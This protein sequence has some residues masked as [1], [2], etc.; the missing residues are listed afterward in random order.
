MSRAQGR[1]AAGLGARSGGGGART[2]ASASQLAGR[3]RE[4]AAGDRHTQRPISTRRG[5]AARLPLRRVPGLGRDGSPE[6]AGPEPGAGGARDRGGRSR[7][8]RER[9]ESLAQ[10]GRF[11]GPRLHDPFL[12]WG[13]RGAL[14]GF[15]AHHRPPRAQTVLFRV[16]Q[17]HRFQKRSRPGPG[18]LTWVASFAWC[19][20]QA[21][22]TCRVGCRGVACGPREGASA[23]G[24]RAWSIR[25]CMMT[26]CICAACSSSI[27]TMSERGG[28][29]THRLL[30]LAGP[31]L[32]TELPDSVLKQM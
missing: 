28:A 24:G 19:L 18:V 32:R 13:N 11:L 8:G 2:A 20:L 7:R 9:W 12:I 31:H 16:T 1:P 27:S 25:L 10:G 21:E 5:A 6:W 23:D 29:V 22:P 3:R 4:P 30:R 15:T 17:M 26:W 14:G